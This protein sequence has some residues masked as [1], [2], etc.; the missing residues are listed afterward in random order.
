MH[1]NGIICLEKE[2]IITELN[3]GLKEHDH[4]N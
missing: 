1:L 4:S 2:A 3:E